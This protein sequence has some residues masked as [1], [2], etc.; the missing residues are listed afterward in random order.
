MHLKCLHN[1]CH[2][3][4]VPLYVS[5]RGVCNSFH[6]L[7]NRDAIHKLIHKLLH[8]SGCCQGNQNEHIF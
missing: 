5:D 1:Y 6:V 7:C 4:R 2:G 8:N 3:S